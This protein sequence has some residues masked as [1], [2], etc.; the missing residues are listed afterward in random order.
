MCL[1]AVAIAGISRQTRLRPHAIAA[2][3]ISMENTYHACAFA[4]LLPESELLIVIAIIGILI[5]MLLPAVNAARES[6]ARTLSI[7]N[8]KQIGLAMHNFEGA[9]GHFPPGYT[10]A[11][12]TPGKPPPAG[13]DMGNTASGNC[14]Y[15]APPG[16]AWARV[17][18]AV[19]G[20]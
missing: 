20:V 9:M 16:W 5:G 12:Y 10:S 3:A 4:A 17:P 11:Q 19:L 1:A 18:P 13:M 14:T 6:A 7:N 2:S 15:D 8:L